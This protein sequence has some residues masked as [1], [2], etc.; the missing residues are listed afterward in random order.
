MVGKRLARLYYHIEDA[1]LQYLHDLTQDYEMVTQGI[2]QIIKG[3]STK[4]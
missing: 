4:I 1:G 2:Y 3:E